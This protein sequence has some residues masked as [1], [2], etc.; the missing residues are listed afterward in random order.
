MNVEKKLEF[1]GRAAQYDL[2]GEASSPTVHR[3]KDDIGR[4]LYPA[5]LPDG[6]RVILLKILLS[7]ACVNNCLYCANRVERDCPRMSFTPEELASIFDNLWRK[8]LV[9]GLFLSSAVD[10]NPDD[11]MARMIAVAE[12]IRRRYGFPG[13]IHLK[14][15]PGATKAA[16]EA[17]ARW[18]TR[19]SVNLEAPSPEALKR[20]APDKDFTK[21]LFT[22]I[23][24]IK[25][26][27][28]EGKATLPAGQTTQFMVGPGGER[29][30]DLLRLVQTL[31]RD[32]GLQ[33]VYYSA[34]QPI[35]DTPLENHPPTPAWREHRLYQADFLIRH[36]MFTV[37]ELTFDS[38]GNLPR[39]GDP[40]LL[41]ALKHPEFF[42]VEINTADYHQLLR[43]PGIG[44]RSA[45][46]IISERK[47]ESIR[48]LED[49]R[50]LGVVTGR[51]APFI[52]LRGK[53]PGFQMTLL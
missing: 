9:N 33:R 23:A 20:I 16:V 46:R 38:E 49:L 2:C 24:W 40:K 42:P 8:G 47:R 21:S 41:W 7:N 39:E 18:A 6:R 25:E 51:A 53:K 12:I 36:Y 28:E 30:R 14:V 11:V 3:V 31:Y 34:F 26:L 35:P 27:V 19:I 5:V 52:T 50:K 22:P 10:G 13:Y 48:S 44:P 29:D 4:W 15:I 43:V 1:L 37:E 32:F 45:R 17:M